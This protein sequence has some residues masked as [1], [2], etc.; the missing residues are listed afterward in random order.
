MH[1]LCRVL[2]SFKSSV[3]TYSGVK[4]IFTFIVFP[5]CVCVCVQSFAVDEAVVTGGVGRAASRRYR[6]RSDSSSG[7]PSLKGQV[8]V[9]VWVYG[10]GCMGVWVWVCGCMVCIH[11]S[12]FPLHR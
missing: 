11:M 5:V 4:F 10:Y 1:I 7:E 3:F 6:I 2:G 12:L 8:G 9:W